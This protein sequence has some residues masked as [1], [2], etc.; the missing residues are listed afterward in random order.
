MEKNPVDDIKLLIRSRY[1]LVYIETNDF[2]HAE[3]VMKEVATQ[4]AIPFYQ[5]SN[6]KGLYRTDSPLYETQT[7]LKALQNIEVFE[8]PGLYFMEALET[9][10]EDSMIL[11][12][13]KEVIDI[14]S[15]KSAAIILTG[16]SINIPERIKPMSAR[17]EF[18]PPSLDDY[19]KLLLTLVKDLSSKMKLTVD[20]TVEQGHQLLQNLK[21]LTLLEAEKILT[22]VMV[23]DNALHED[24]I[25]RV[26]EAKKEIL[27]RDGLLEYCPAQ[28][29]LNDVAGLAGLKNWLIKRKDI[30]LYPEKAKAFGLPFP[31]G[32]LLLGV[33]GCGKSLCAK[34][35]SSEWKL[36]L[37]KL[38]PS[39]MYSKWAGESE[40]N[41]KTALQTA[42][43]MA[44]VILWIDELEKAFA[45]GS[46]D[47]DGGV[48]KRIFGSFLT[49]LQEHQGD[50]FIVATANDIETLPPEFLRKGRFDEIFFVDLPTAEIRK[51][52]FSIHLKKRGHDLSKFDLDSLTSATEGFSPAEIEQSIVSGLYTAFSSHQ[53]LTTDILMKEVKLT[54]PLSTVMK[55]KIDGLRAWAKE[56]TVSAD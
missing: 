35:I 42:E 5:W 7:P 48:S 45:S 16:S 3:A 13:L 54:R 34:A 2:Y 6:T 25:Q 19:K 52:V 50:V 26:I 23:I 18:P 31:K 12:K 8:T 28:D 46:D 37:L 33:Q 40:K 1:G 17:V 32:I 4:M 56:R 15:Q 21:G 44:P 10:F 20:L 27:S 22:Q 36:P 24:D 55:E 41:F 9:Y 51:N 39:S 29:K 53:E 30:L 43:R 49:W 38:D 11:Q 14:L 47:A